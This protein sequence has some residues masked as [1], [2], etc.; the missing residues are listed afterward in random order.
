MIVKQLLQKHRILISRIFVIAIITLILF[1]NNLWEKLPIAAN[2][3]FLIG[4]FLIGIATVG[5]LWC[6]LY[7]SG[8]KT[9][10]LI[11][12]G[13]YSMSRN[14]LYF[15]SL[16]GAIG[17]ALTSE[18]LSVAILTIIAFAIYYPNVIE[19]EENTLR[20]V[21]GENF[22]TYCKNVPKFFPSF[23]LLKEPDEYVVK[24]IIFKQGIFDAL[25]FIWIV[26]FLEI[27]KLLHHL[28]IMP[29]Y[30]SIY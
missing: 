21:H 16:L 4:I 17:V 24:P 3:Y 29:M 13:P 20:K 1:S 15:F 12:M 11:T 9:N 2:I 7:I 14:P 8:Y 18:I 10:T 26:G 22:E 5:R 27:I 25:W 6:L 23:F 30:F 19:A 28:N